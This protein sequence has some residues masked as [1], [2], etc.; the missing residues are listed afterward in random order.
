VLA[1]IGLHAIPLPWAASVGI[2]AGFDALVGI[3]CVLLARSKLTQPVM[4]ESRELLRRTL[5]AA[6]A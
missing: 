3:T 1:V 5:E 2:V 6:K 4:L